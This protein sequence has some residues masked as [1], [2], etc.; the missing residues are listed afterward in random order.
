MEDVQ[1]VRNQA[2]FLECEQGFAVQETEKHITH[3]PAVLVH[4]Q[5]AEQRET[6][7]KQQKPPQV[8]PLG[9]EP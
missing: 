3:Q 5:L 8:Q 7:N 6:K 2:P 9:A 1:R 4:C